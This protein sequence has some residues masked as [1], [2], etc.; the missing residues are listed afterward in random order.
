MTDDMTFSW[1]IDLFHLHYGY[2]LMQA[3]VDLSHPSWEACYRGGEKYVFVISFHSLQSGL[4]SEMW[5]DKKIRS[6]TG[7]SSLSKVG[8][9]LKKSV[10]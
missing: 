7:R 6:L 1:V 2:N 4:D 3:S 5:Y 8:A 10:D 9:I